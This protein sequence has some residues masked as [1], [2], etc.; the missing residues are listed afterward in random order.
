MI[1]KISVIIWK[2]FYISTQKKYEVF[3][4]MKNIV[5]KNNNYIITNLI[6]K[7]NSSIKKKKISKKIIKK[8]R[9]LKKI[10]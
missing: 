2:Y 8:S 4:T 7:F 1:L 9:Q 6:E 3:K 5:C 10:F